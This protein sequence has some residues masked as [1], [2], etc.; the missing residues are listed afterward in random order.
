MAIVVI[1]LLFSGYGP[2]TVFT[3]SS[4]GRTRAP[5]DAALIVVAGVTAWLATIW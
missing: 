4:P 5:F 3:R 1:R 2:M